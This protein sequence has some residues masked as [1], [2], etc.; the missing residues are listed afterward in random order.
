MEYATRTLTRLRGP[1]NEATDT[2]KS[3]RES[4]AYCHS[5]G[6]SVA[7]LGFLAEPRS[8]GNERTRERVIATF[9]TKDPATVSESAAAAVAARTTERNKGSG[10]K[11]RPENE[12]G[13]QL[14][15]EGT[16]SCNAI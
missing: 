1:A 5:G 6:V 2:V 10:P 8:P 9:T 13:P 15:L 3:A 16:N 7:A 12:L 11:W 14:A 4:P